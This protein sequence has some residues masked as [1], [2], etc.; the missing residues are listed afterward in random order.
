MANWRILSI[1]VAS[2][3]LMLSVAI[4]QAVA[5]PITEEVDLGDGALGR[6]RAPAGPV[7]R[8]A[9]LAIHRTSD[10]RN[11]A[12][13]TNLADRGFGTLGIRTRFGNSEAAVNFELIALDVRNGIRFLKNVKGHTHVILI[14]H[15]GGGP[16][17]SYF[18]ALAENGPS[19]C[20]GRNKLTECPFYGS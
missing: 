6:Y 19:Y 3:L 2:F 18:Q 9:F 4:P 1:V 14:G 12:S 20:Q 13:S 16:T 5:Q 8:I 15:S 7:S 17:T 11:H 10:Y